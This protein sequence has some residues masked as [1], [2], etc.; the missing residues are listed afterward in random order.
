MKRKVHVSWNLCF[1]LSSETACRG[2]RL[3]YGRSVEMQICINAAIYSLPMWKK[4]RNFSGK[5]IYRPFTSLLM[6]FSVSFSVFHGFFRASVETEACIMVMARYIRD[7]SGIAEHVWTEYACSARW[8]S[9]RQH[10]WS[11]VYLVD[12]GF[13]RA[14]YFLSSSGDS[15]AERVARIFTPTVIVTGEMKSNMPV[16]LAERTRKYKIFYI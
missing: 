6:L 11:V 4:N 10:N 1:P 16:I 13:N 2:N 3:P 8:V 9:R 7:F 5:P 15:F 12:T 14:L